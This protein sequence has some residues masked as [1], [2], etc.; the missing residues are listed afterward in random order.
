MPLMYRQYGGGM[1]VF[2]Y[3]AQKI[4]FRSDSVQYQC[5]ACK[6]H[7][8][9]DSLCDGAIHKNCPSSPA[10]HLR[11]TNYRANVAHAQRKEKIALSA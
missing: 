8:A 9:S 11:G 10:G 5:S 2:Q 7:Y 4:G 6:D 3:V 1:A